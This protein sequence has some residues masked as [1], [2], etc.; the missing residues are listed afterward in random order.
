MKARGPIPNH[1]VTLCSPTDHFSSSY[2][3]KGW[4]CGYRNLQMLL[5]SLIQL[6][7]Y[8]K[9]ILKGSFG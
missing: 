6:E 2:G 7:H 3:D 5:S 4:G 8:K 9:V 1:V